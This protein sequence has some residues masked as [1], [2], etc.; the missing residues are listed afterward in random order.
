MVLAGNDTVIVAVPAFKMVT[1]PFDTDTTFYAVWKSSY[2]MSLST[3]TLRNNTFESLP[4]VPNGD[5][6]AEVTLTNIACMVAV[7]L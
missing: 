1:V 2:K 3:N 6:I 7:S 5:F 4:N